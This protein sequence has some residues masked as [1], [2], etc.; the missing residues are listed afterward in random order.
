MAEVFLARSH[1]IGRVDKLVAVKLVSSHLADEPAIVAMLQQEARLTASLDHPNIAAVL[2]FA[3]CE[4]EPFLVCEYV[5]GHSLQDVL[6][7]AAERGSPLPLGVA[8]GI[9]R[10]IAEAL[11]Y[12]HEACDADG[13]P[14]GI[15]HRD[16]SPSNVL[17]RHDGVVKVVDFG[18]AKATSLPGA[19]ESGTLKGT[20]GSMAP[21]QCNGLDVDRRTDVFALGI[22][23]FEIT[24]G[25]RLFT[26]RNDFEVM[27]RIAKG[28]IVRPS[29]VRADYPPALER[30][31]LRALAT[32]PSDRQPDAAEIQREI[33]AFAR[34]EKLDTS[35][36]A[37]REC[38]DGLVGP[39]PHP[40]LE[41]P[42]ASP[43]A[44]DPPS[45]STAERARRRTWRLALAGGSVVACG[46]TIAVARALASAPEVAE[47]S[48]ES[49]APEPAAIAPAVAPAQPPPP[50][51]PAPVVAPIEPPAA[52]SDADDQRPRGKSRTPK[53]TSRRSASATRTEPSAAPR[54]PTRRPSRAL[55]PDDG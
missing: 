2:D 7:A 37:L 18:I 14:L 47:R 31:V 53:R 27:N 41:M 44:A 48:D 49:A 51:E 43:S 39:R 25:F 13:R 34:E 29:S 55:F 46:L 35:S 19:T 50:T 38:L 15:V 36:L 20:R 30:I 52:A 4:D 10:A 32:S 42:V 12:A 28:E 5:H 54:E 22:V 9:A 45:S 26:G 17:L 33:E 11:H 23:L 16:V 3:V 1:G 8:V 40:A 21:E 24:T 6:K